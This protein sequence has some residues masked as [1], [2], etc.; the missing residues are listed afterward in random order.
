M[1]S[2]HLD[3]DFSEAPIARKVIDAYLLPN[4]VPTDAKKTLRTANAN[5]QP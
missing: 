5:A 2:R 4:E 1:L 3:L